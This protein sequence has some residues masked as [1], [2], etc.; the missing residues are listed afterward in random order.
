MQLF[1]VDPSLINSE[2]VELPEE[3]SRHIAAVLRMQEGEEIN[4][5]N[6]LGT[7]LTAVIEDAHKKRTRVR[8]TVSKQQEAPKQRIMMGVSL[9]KN[10][11]R[12]EWFLE[13][14][15][16]IGVTDI[17]PMICAR[18]EKQQFRLDR[19]KTILVS[20]MMQSNQ[21]WLPRMTEP[22]KFPV[23]IEQLIQVEQPMIA[24]CEPSEKAVLQEI[25][26][27]DSSRSIL[28]GPEGDFSPEEINLAT[29]KGFRPVTLGNTRLR[30]ETACI[31]AATLLKNL[32]Q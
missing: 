2:L 23:A 16:E 3:S 17:I 9:L 15:T 5:T 10:T 7:L 6:G 32:G 31:V 13:K 21:F 1:Y 22:V 18:T 20:A 4:L 25:L 19:M 14:A 30:T 27:K 11:G 12:F 28:I 24:H 29:G 26:M 8:I